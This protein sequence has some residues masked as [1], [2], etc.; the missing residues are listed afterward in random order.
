[1]KKPV[2]KHLRQA[3]PMLDILTRLSKRKRMKELAEM[4]GEIKLY[5]ALHEIAFNTIKG[6]VK[7]TE[8]QKRK[9]KPYRKTLEDLCKKKYK[10]CIKKRKELI[11]QSGG[12]LPIVL[13][14]IVSLLSAILNNG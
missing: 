4:G 6:P 10:N 1:M 9:I 3:L 12:F 2:S 14:T 8:V 11:I 7:L 13:P 5:N